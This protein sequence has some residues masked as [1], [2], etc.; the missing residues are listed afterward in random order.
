LS[1]KSCIYIFDES[2]SALDENS[3][4]KC[5]NLLKQVSK[6]ACVLIISHRKK[7][8][9]AADVLYELKDNQLFQIDKTDGELHV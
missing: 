1:K 7:T 9:D 6:T 4:I 5:L 2:T 3:E 8:L